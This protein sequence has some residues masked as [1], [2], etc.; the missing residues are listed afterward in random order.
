MKNK[1]IHLGESFLD[2]LVKY[3]YGKNSLRDLSTK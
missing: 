3:T 1:N 2:R